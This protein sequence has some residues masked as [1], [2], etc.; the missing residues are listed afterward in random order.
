MP[1][2]PNATFHLDE[3]ELIL[4]DPS[5][6]I[7]RCATR[8]NAG[9]LQEAPK[10]E[11]LRCVDCGVVSASRMPVETA[12]AKFY[13]QYYQNDFYQNRKE[14]VAVQAPQRL[15]GHI[16]E[17]IAKY[18][19]GKRIHILDFGG[20]DGSVAFWLGKRLLSEG[21]SDNISITVIDYDVNSVSKSDS[22]SIT[23]SKQSALDP[24]LD[25]QYDIVLASA[26][27]EHLTDP[28]KVF[29]SLLKSLKTG[30]LLYARTPYMVPLRQ[31]L[32]L[33][34]VTIDFTYPAHLHD[35]GSRF[36][37]RILATLQVQDR[38]ELQTSRPS[39]VETLFATNFLRTL[40]AYI[41]KAP[42]Y[43]FGDIW[44]LVGGWEVIIRRR[45]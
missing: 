2:N 4:P 3:S 10:I 42:W 26:I 44:P 20:G 16:F 9:V 25:G 43:L 12:L 7:C 22:E 19:H 41:F 33:F 13:E 28:R 38:F 8:K 39:F 31:L 36:W 24:S 30:G 27:L 5:C 15:A 29:E 18:P 37:N 1:K 17:Y 40:A 45:Q 32:R 14:R 11:L 35:M 34:G 21:L 23:I 6:L